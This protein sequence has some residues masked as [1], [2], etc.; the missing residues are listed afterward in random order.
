MGSA[1]MTIS[2]LITIRIFFAGWGLTIYQNLQYV[3]RSATKEYAKTLFQ[4]NLL[5]SIRTFPIS[6]N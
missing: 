2:A 6:G 3:E 1:V 5:P 4:K